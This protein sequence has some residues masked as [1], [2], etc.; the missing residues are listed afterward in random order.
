MMDLPCPLAYLWDK[1]EADDNVQKSHK[2][3]NGH[4]LKVSVIISRRIIVNVKMSLKTSYQP[5][6][7]LNSRQYHHYYIAL[8]QTKAISATATKI[9]KMLK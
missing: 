3:V 6:G 1:D 9:A 2:Y 7:G 4:G 8:Q 5:H